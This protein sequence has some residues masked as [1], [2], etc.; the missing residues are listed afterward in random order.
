MSNGFLDII[1]PVSG[2]RIPSGLYKCSL[3]TESSDIYHE[4]EVISPFKE[5]RLRFLYISWLDKGGVL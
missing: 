5:A 3:N 2:K 1:E 4:R